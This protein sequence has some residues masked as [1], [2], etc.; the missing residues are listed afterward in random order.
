MRYEGIV[1]R[2]PSEASELIGKI[3]TNRCA[4]NTCTFCTYKAK[5]FRVRSMEEIMEDLRKSRQQLRSL[6]PEGIWQTETPW[7]FRQR[8]FWK[9]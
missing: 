6:C 7:C 5:D 2:P 8:S 3:C 4:H 9:F 1:Y